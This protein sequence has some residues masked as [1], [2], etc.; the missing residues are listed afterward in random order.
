MEGRVFERG[1]D[2]WGEGDRERERGRVGGRGERERK[3]G[4]EGGRDGGSSTTAA[5]Y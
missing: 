4:R 2:G 1:R 5:Y 3:G